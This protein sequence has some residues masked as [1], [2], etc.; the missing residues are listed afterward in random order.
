VL[1]AQ[2]TDQLMPKMVINE[3]GPSENDILEATRHLPVQF[4]RSSP[5]NQINSAFMQNEVSC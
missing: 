4:P 3:K 1:V 2:R 5:V